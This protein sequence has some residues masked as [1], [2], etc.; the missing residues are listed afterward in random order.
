MLNFTRVGLR[1]GKAA[2]GVSVGFLW[3]RHSDK[4]GCR[5]KT[6]GF[7]VWRGNRMTGY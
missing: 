1:A 2:A 3:F 7:N 4:I 5:K 6:L